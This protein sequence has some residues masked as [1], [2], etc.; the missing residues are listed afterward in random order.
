MSI[1]KSRHVNTRPTRKKL[2]F[3]AI[4]VCQFI[5]GCT[6]SA[7]ITPNLAFAKTNTE[8]VVLSKQILSVVDEVARENGFH[9]DGSTIPENSSSRIEA[10]YTQTDEFLHHTTAYISVF[11]GGARSLDGTLQPKTGQTIASV[12]IEGKALG[13]IP[14][15][16]LRRFRRRLPNVEFRPEEKS[17]YTFV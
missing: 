4:V 8:A 12:S 17:E 16:I 9:R 2:L 1:Q 15:K 3:S 10:A 6:Q 14:G 7:L 13:G 5:T 11:V